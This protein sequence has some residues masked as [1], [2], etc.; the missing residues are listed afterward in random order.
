M[1]NENKKVRNVLIIALLLAI[2]IAFYQIHEGRSY[3]PSLPPFPDTV[4][5][6]SL[7]KEGEFESIVGKDTIFFSEAIIASEFSKGFISRPGATKVGKCE[8]EF[9]YKG[10][11]VKQALEVTNR[12]IVLGNTGVDEVENLEKR[13]QQFKTQKPFNIKVE[14]KIHDNEE[15]ELEAIYSI[16]KNGT[17]KEFWHART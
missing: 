13:Y 8:I 4:K 5:N 3:N 16:E 15:L 17:E 11:K 6:E 10:K 9:T 2:G 14:G 7:R 12:G 1:E